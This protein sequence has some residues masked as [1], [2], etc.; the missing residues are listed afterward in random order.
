MCN[1]QDKYSMIVIVWFQVNFISTI[2]MEQKWLIYLDLKHLKLIIIIIPITLI[3]VNTII[4]VI[5]IVVIVIIA[6]FMCI[7]R[8]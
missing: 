2:I 4:M 8:E 7:I 5:V 6:T 1:A 3:I